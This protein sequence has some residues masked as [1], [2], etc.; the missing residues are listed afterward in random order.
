VQGS[1]F[2]LTIRPDAPQFP[3]LTLNF[4]E[5]RLVAVDLAAGCRTGAKGQSLPVH[6]VV[7]AP[8]EYLLD[9][10]FLNDA[11][12]NLPQSKVAG[13]WLWF[14]RFDERVASETEP[15]NFKK[16]VSAL[17]ASM[18]VMNLHGGFFRLALSRHG[19]AE[20]AH[21]VGYGEQKD[22]VPVIGQSTPTVRYYVP[23]LYA[24]F[25]VPD[26]E[27]CFTSLGVNTSKDF[28]QM[29]C[30]CVVCRGVIATSLS[31]FRQFGERHYSTPLSKRA[32]QTSAAAK[33]CRFHFL[34]CRLRKRD[35]IADK[36][37]DDVIKQLSDC[38]AQ[39]KPMVVQDL[40]E[41]AAQ[42]ERWGKVLGTTLTGIRRRKAT[43]VDFVAARCFRAQQ[44]SI[45]FNRMPVSA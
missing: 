42:M 37:N 39:W 31:N 26:I 9:T 28:F 33:R 20:I 25:G 32:A 3:L 8:R 19:M 7:C 4:K 15:L 44:G 10:A 23:T 21:G 36:S 40:R 6:A 18:Q 12:T 24:R 14:S 29:I 22:V 27:R 1:T 16:L 35:W 43:V 13:V 30:D 17:G 45:D 5:G 2:R 41:G 38:A 34:L 11:V